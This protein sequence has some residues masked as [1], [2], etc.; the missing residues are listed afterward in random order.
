LRLE[1]ILSIAEIGDASAVRS[2]VLL[3]NESDADIARAAA[4]AL[5]GLSGPEADSEVAKLLDHADPKLK[6][7]LVEIAGQRR[8]A[9]AAPIVLK[10]M[11]DQDVSV[12]AAAIKGYGD[13]TGAGGI[14]ILL[15]NL[16]KSADAKEISLYERTLGT[17]CPLASDKAACTKALI[18]A[19]AR[20]APAVKPALLRTLR[21]TGGPDSLQAVRAAVDD[22]NTEVHAAAVRTI[23]EWPSAEASPV[24]LELAKNSAVPIDK[25]LALR[26]YLGLA[27]QK[28]VPVTDKLAICREA[29]AL[30]QREEEK[31]MLLGAIGNAASPESF[32]LIV[33]YLDDPSVRQEAVATV[34]AVAEKRKPK[35]NT[36]AAMQALEKVAKV[37]AGDPAA[38]KRAEELLKQLRNEK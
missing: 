16:L 32:E 25:A 12:R 34:M 20:A 9:S 28:S 1:A 33:P 37:A 6:I 17:V 7:K 2:I 3:L 4:A 30:V 14:P 38:S 21:V 19:L 13:L 24:L 5:A 27:M 18:D 23:G 35:Q 15:D 26:G 8:M 22:P 31:R 29:A 10:A 11:S 36:A